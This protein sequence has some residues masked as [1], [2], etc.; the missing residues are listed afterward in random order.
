M[1]KKSTIRTIPIT[2]LQ[3]FSPMTRWKRPL[4][5]P[6]GDTTGTTK[7]KQELVDESLG[8]PRQTEDGL[9]VVVQ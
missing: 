4:R 5:E 9:V 2:Y 3:R 6:E 8:K 1:E 7:C